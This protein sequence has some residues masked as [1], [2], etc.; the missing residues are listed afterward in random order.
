MP[1]FFF[2]FHDSH[3]PPSRDDIGLSL[4]SLAHAKHEAALALVGYG[5]EVVGVFEDRQLRV[6]IR[7]HSWPVAEITC[8]IMVNELAIPP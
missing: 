3:L 4:E 1:Q 7:T 6:T 8:D 2:D 5:A